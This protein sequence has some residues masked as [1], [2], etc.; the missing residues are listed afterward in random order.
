[1]TDVLAEICAEKHAHIAR[2]KVVRS[3]AAL[4]AAISEAPPVRP[5]A[6]ALESHLAEG[7]YGLIAEIKKA[8]PSAGVICADFDPVRIAREYEAKLKA[9]KEQKARSSIPQFRIKNA[10]S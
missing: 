8:S 3:E 5:F 7:R 9:E 4:L 10:K 6:A 1:M 2:A